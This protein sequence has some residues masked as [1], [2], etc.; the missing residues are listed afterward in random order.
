[1]GADAVTDF[2]VR[3]GGG[4]WAYRERLVSTRHPLLRRIR[5]FIYT[6]Y[7]ESLG[8]Y[9]GRGATFEGPPVFPHKPTGVFISA[10]SRIGRGVT[11]YQQVT[12]GENNTMGSK[13]FGSPTIGDDVYIG[14]GA[15]IIGRVTIGDGARVGAGAIVVTDVPPGGLAVSPRAEIR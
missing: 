7:L 15:K 4:F 12:I 10:D 11:I 2:L 8:S 14:A 1:M 13:R 5:F 6:H 9:I 3:A